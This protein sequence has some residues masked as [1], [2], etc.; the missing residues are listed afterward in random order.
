MVQLVLDTDV[1]LS[2][3]LS[4]TGASRQLLMHALKGHITGL[5]SVPLLVEYEAVM[6]RPE[7]MKK[8]AASLNDVDMI[9]DRIATVFQP[10]NLYYSWRPFLRDADD[11]MVLETAINGGANMIATFNIK[12]F[13]GA[14]AGFGI[15]A[16]KPG[17][18]LRRQKW[19]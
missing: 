3:M 17:D 1:V 10:V 11:D 8:A 14:N 16:M 6:K 2:S 19:K 5:V 12:D 7:H 9:L 13:S 4:A 18:I 15:H